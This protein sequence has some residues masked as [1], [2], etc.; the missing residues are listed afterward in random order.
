MTHYLAGGAFV[1]SLFALY[2]WW[3][4]GGFRLRGNP[5]QPAAGVACAAAAAAYALLILAMVLS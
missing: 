2:A 1:A 4:A 3:L 5:W